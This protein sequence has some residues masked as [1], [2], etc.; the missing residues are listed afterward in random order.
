MF[1]Y[2]LMKF[3]LD[4]DKCEEKNSKKI[5]NFKDG[6][7]TFAFKKLATVTVNIKD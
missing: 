4:Y 7:R 1:S 2:E 6:N 5:Y 3:L